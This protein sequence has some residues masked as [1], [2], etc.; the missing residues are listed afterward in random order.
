VLVPHNDLSDENFLAITSYEISLNDQ[1][2]SDFQFEKTY[3]LNLYAKDRETDVSSVFAE[4]NMWIEHSKKYISDACRKVAYN[5]HY[6]IE[7]VNDLIQKANEEGFL[8]CLNHPV[9]S[10]QRYPDYAGLKGLWGVE[11]Y[12]TG[13]VR[14]GYAECT[15]AFDDL[16]HLNEMVYPVAADDAHSVEDCG[17]GWIQVKADKLEYNTVMD[18]LERGDFYASTGP[19]IYD[20]Y[21]EDGVV[22]VSTS[23]AVQIALKTE[24]RVYF[25]KNGN[26]KEPVREAS[27]DITQYLAD[28]R[29]NPNL[30]YRPWFRIEVL[31]KQGNSAQTRAY[32]T[33]ELLTS[34]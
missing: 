18:A 8:V 19:E 26:E 28:T 31:D 20:L 30:R 21:I 3:H 5:R 11:V 6:S 1:W 4:K 24:R 14:S 25:A 17:G 34:L 22:H 23:D 33:K 16:L 27:F 10:M 12:N 32:Q 13:C 29:K 2:P 9:W 15:Q 7:G